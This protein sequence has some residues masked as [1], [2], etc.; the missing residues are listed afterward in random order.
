LDF[1]IVKKGRLVVGEKKTLRRN[2]E[3]A[4]AKGEEKAATRGKE[5]FNLT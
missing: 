2:E 3:Y 4:D 5:G 1:T